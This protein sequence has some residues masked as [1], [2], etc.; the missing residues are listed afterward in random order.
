LALSASILS[1]SQPSP[2]VTTGTI[3]P[4]TTIPGNTPSSTSTPP[5]SATETTTPVIT[6]TS[7]LGD[8]TFLVNVNPANVDNSKLPVT[9]VNKIHL[10]GSDPGIDITN[11]RLTVDGLV[12]KPLSLTYE[13]IKQYPTVTEVVL[14]ICPGLFADNAEWTGVPVATILAQA[15][16]KQEGYGIIT[17]YESGQYKK[18]FYL[19]D[20]QGDGVFLAYMVDGQV[21]PKEHGFPLRL[22]VKG[23][24]GNNWVKWVDRIEIT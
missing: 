6:P 9:P 20:L 15:G 12:D 1:C 22:V 7:G 10:T 21:L 24:W 8:L 5:P 17:F 14:L 19:K 18:S 16:L 4:H 2:I 23:Q 11:Y 13:D 3:P